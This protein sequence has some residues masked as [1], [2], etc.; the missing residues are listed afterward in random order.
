MVR[1]K[2]TPKKVENV[3]KREFYIF[4]IIVALIVGLFA[5]VSDYYII[6]G[7]IDLE[8]QLSEQ[9]TS[10]LKWGETIVNPKYA[11]TLVIPAEVD[12]YFICTRQLK[13]E[14]KWVYECGEWIGKASETKDGGSISW[15]ECIEPLD[16]KEIEFCLEVR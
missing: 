5:T 10:E 15:E 13:C 7:V 3:T 11:G 12:D 8:S 1:L 2:K 6:E 9:D 4:V 14:K 16:L